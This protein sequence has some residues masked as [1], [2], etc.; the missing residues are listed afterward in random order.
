MKH[1]LSTEL[2]LFSR[3]LWSVLRRRR[4]RDVARKGFA[5]TTA[6]FDW[7]GFYIGGNVGARPA[8]EL[9]GD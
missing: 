6:P 8:D 5:R 4:S 1:A 9:D 3:S 7:T 2:S